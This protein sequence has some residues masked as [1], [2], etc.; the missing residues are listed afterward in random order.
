MNGF[1]KHLPN[2]LTG[3][4]IAAAPTLAFLL[5]RGA[6]RAA[7]GVFAFAGLSDA[8]DGFLAK[9]FGLTTRFGRFLDPVADKLLMIAS[10]AT[11][12]VLNVAP[13]WLTS[14]VLARDM[15]IVAGV[16]AAS[17]LRIPI[18]VAPLLVGKASTAM[19]IVYIALALIL[20]TFDLQWPQVENAA[21]DATA[22]LTIASWLGYAIVGANALVR[23]RSAA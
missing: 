3:L 10:F 9:R 23:R 21:A 8:A 12:T 17:I 19:Q 4:R 18:R 22:L 1:L 20:L 6:D 14:L 16:S 11:L 15:A 2:F 13:L 5:V 7:L